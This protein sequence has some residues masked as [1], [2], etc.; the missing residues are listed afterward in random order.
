M[1][2]KSSP[3]NSASSASIGGGR[4]ELTDR[5]RP[6]R[7]HGCSTAEIQADLAHRNRV[8]T[9]GELTAS[10]A[11]EIK[12]P[13]AAAAIHASACER[14]LQRDVPDVMEACEAASAMVAD[15]TRAANIIDRVRS[16][17]G[18]GMPQRE[19]VDVNEIIGEMV[20]LLNDTARWNS[21]STRTELDVELPMT[22]ADRVQLQQVLMNLML[23]GIEAM[24][25][26]GG[27]LAV[28]SKNTDDGQLLISVSDSGIGLPVEETERIFVAF[29]T[30]KPQGT[31]MGLA[32]CRSIIESHGGR[33]WA[34][35]NKGR[36]A[37]FH[38]TL[39]KRSGTP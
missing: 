1:L 36:G 34:S 23:N 30:T 28:T 19:L 14:W 38:F 21:I 13:L 29:F 31:G 37:T 3:T 39:P 17:Y 12:Q 10:L 22:T 33:L 24:K 9:V 35:A 25:D 20:A 32:I 5:N 8:A 4:D 2:T 18:R 6:R 15:V 7:S 16:L 26:T 27:E 11:H